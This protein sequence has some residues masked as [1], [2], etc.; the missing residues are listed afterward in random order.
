MFLQM[1]TRNPLD[2]L[3]CKSDAIGSSFY[4]ELRY[5]DEV[6][7]GCGKVAQL[8]TCEASKIM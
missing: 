6:G 1:E 7:F 8:I 4:F 3:K 2:T 5:F